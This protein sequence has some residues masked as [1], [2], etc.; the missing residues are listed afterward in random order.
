MVPVP[1]FTFIFH[2]SVWSM[3]ERPWNMLSVHDAAMLDEKDKVRHALRF[4]LS[5]Q[6]SHTHLFSFRLSAGRCP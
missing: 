6:V 3:F 4:S 5:T 2:L 1:F